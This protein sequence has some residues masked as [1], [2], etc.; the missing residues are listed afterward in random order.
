MLKS[1]TQGPQYITIT[2]TIKQID[3]N[4]YEVKSMSNKTKAYE[5]TLIDQGL[6]ACSCPDFEFRLRQCKHIAEVL[7]KVVGIL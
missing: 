7:I 3:I 5:V 4:K 6:G 2:E 1:G